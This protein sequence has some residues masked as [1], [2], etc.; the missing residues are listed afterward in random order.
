MALKIV[1]WCL[2]GLTIL[3]VLFTVFTVETCYKNSAYTL[4]TLP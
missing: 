1:K 2:I 3:S 4:I